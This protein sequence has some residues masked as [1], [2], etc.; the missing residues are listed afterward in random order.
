MDPAA[1]MPRSQSQQRTS[2]GSYSSPPPAPYSAPQAPALSV[3]GPITAN[4]EQ[5]LAY[6]GAIGK[7]ADSP[8][9][10][11]WETLTKASQ[12]RH[13]AG[14]QGHRDGRVQSPGETN[15]EAVMVECGQAVLG[16]RTKDSEL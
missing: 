10:S 3:T 13:Y 7:L 12:A 16:S 4:S 2:A 1:T 9:S 15:A 11:F 14:C 6:F 8:Y 5:V